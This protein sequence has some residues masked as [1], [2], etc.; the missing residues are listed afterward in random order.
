MS[1]FEP[2]IPPLVPGAPE[3]VLRMVRNVVCAVLIASGGTLAHAA[4]TD[5]SHN[6]GGAFVGLGFV[7]D[8]PGNSV[9]EP[10]E[11]VVLTV[12]E[13]ARRGVTSGCAAFLTGTFAL[14]L[15]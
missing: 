3:T 13:L 8:T 4:G 14:G 2:E 11:T 7:I 5:G 1:C 9:M 6:G 12:E 15:Y 10:D